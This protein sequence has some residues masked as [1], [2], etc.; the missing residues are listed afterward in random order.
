MEQI[1]E[2]HI[3]I[4]KFPECDSDE[5]E[6]FKQQD[7]E[8]KVSLTKVIDQG[9][10]IKPVL[11]WVTLKK[12]LFLQSAIPFA[13]VGSNTVV[14]VAGKKVRGRMYQWGIVEGERGG[15]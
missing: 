3:N 13:V 2:N 1:E 5:D 10:Q 8:L 14:E 9:H 11:W 15:D 4:Y 7:R 12:K 6:E